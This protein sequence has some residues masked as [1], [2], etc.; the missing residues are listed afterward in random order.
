[1]LYI[2]SRSAL[3]ALALRAGVKSISGFNTITGN[4][5]LVRPWLSAYNT[6]EKFSKSKNTFNV[7]VAEIVP[8][9]R[10][11][12]PMA[13]GAIVAL[14]SI[15]HTYAQIMVTRRKESANYVS[16]QYISN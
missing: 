6:F 3:V 9:P 13:G 14:P 11:A 7:F 16:I 12:T 10:G 8:G 15:I 2:F 4:Q 5:V 1:M